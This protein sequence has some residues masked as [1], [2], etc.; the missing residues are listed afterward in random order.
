MLG[1]IAALLLVA[2]AQAAGLDAV[3]IAAQERHAQDCPKAGASQELRAA[4]KQR[5]V[6][7]VATL[8]A[9]EPDDAPWRDYWRGMLQQC[10]GEPDA[11]LTDFQAFVRTQGRDAE[12]AGM[13]DD[14]RRRIRVLRR[15][16]G[17]S[18]LGLTVGAAGGAGIAAGRPAGVRPAA[19]LALGLLLPARPVSVWVEGA[20]LLRPVDACPW[21]QRDAP[22]GQLR[23]GAAVPGEGPGLW[24]AAA[25]T[26][27]LLGGTRA[28][29]AR[30]CAAHVADPVRFGSPTREG[31]VAAHE[32]G[33]VAAWFGLGGLVEVGGSLSGVRGRPVFAV[34]VQAGGITPLLWGDESV[35]G[36]RVTASELAPTVRLVA[37]AVVRF[38]DLP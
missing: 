23:V 4:A 11:A 25:G 29:Q 18:D 2:P 16:L 22:G 33:D 34:R 13:A 20:A 19:D 15:Q 5:I 27:S 36:R 30:R 31:L 1:L 10:L 28:A 9:L 6:D 7:A 12:L 37:L 14:A 35:G 17:G 26:V 8:S 21:A 24:L 3:A 38:V 32:L